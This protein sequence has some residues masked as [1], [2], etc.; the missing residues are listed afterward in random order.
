[1]AA[2]VLRRKVHL[3]LSAP[4]ILPSINN[5]LHSPTS[6]TSI[7]TLH[8]KRFFFISFQKEETLGREAL[9]IV[10]CSLLLGRANFLVRGKEILES[11]NC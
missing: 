7:P 1:M 10:L 3:S 8:L 2:V 4:T 11:W 6:T 9:K 5:F